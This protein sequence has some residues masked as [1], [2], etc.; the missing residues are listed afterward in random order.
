MGATLEGD[1]VPSPDG[2]SIWHAML[3]IGDSKVMMADA[4]PGWE[5]GPESNTT[6][7]FFCY[8]EDSDSWFR[9]AVEAGC[10]V[11]DVVDDMFWGDR[12]GRVK[13]P[14]G[15]VWSFATHKWVYTDEEMAARMGG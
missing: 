5:G 12:V 13:D 8:V 11:I 9:R 3:H 7:G 2:D 10:E 6:V 14:F 15:H 1:P 4:V